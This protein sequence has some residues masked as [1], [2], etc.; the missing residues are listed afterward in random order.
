MSQHHINDNINC[1]NNA[2]VSN[3]III[4]NNCTVANEK[5]EI[6]AWLSPLEPQIRHQD[7]STRRVSEVGDSLLQAEGYRNWFGGI[8]GGK[9]DGSALLC[10]RARGLAGPTSGTVL[11][12]K[13]Y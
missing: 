12:E 1:F 10:H 13:R 6:L 7:I 5:S 8:Q 11:Y 2:N 3:N 4:W 9:S